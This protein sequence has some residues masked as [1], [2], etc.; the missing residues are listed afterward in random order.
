MS[1]TTQTILAAIMDSALRASVT[2]IPDPRIEAA[3]KLLAALDH[4]HE[5][6]ETFPARVS[7]AASFLRAMLESEDAQ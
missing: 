7:I 6:G 2:I 4:C 5:R 1:D 3:R